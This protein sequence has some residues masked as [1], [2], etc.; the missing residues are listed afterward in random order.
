[1]YGKPHSRTNNSLHLDQGRVEPG[2]EGG[3]IVDRSGGRGQRSLVDDAHGVDDVEGGAVAS[4]TGQNFGAKRFDRIKEG[5]KSSLKVGI[6][7]ALA[8]DIQLYEAILCRN[9]VYPT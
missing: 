8:M 3:L 9:S 2:G 6:A 1:M 7:Y 4:F 5:Y